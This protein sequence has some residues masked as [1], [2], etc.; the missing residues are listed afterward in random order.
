MRQEAIRI[1][2]SLALATIRP[3]RTAA[4]S[5]PPSVHRIFVC[6]M[7][8]SM[9]DPAPRLRKH[10]K[11]GIA[12]T[13]APGDT[14]SVL[15]FSGR[16]QCGVVFEGVRV[17]D[18]TALSSVQVAIDRFLQPLGLTSFVEPLQEVSRVMDRLSAADPSAAFSLV[19]MSDGYDN[20]GT[21]DAIL[22]ATTALSA[23]VAAGAV[24]EYGW[25]ANRP[26]LTAMAETL[27]VPYVF[28]EDFDRFAPVLDAEFRRQVDGARKREIRLPH[29]ALHGLCFAVRGGS[30]ATFA[31]FDGAARVP[32][33]VEAVHYLTA[34]ADGASA[35]DPRAMDARVV[36]ALYAALAVLSQRMLA[37]EVLA[38]LRLL[39]DVRL[40]RQFSNC[41]GKQSYSAF[42]DAVAAAATDEALRWADGYDPALVPPDDAFTVLDLLAELLADEGN[43]LHV[44]HPAFDYRRIGRRTEDATDRLTREERDEITSLTVSAKSAKDLARVQ[45]RM[46]EIAA[47][48]PRAVRFDANEADAGVPISSLTLNESRPNVS[49]LIRK[50]GTVDVSGN[51]VGLPDRVPTHIFRNF[52]IVRD[53]ILN[54]KR[55]PVSLTHATHGVLAAQG[56]VSG[57]WAPGEV[58]VIDLQALPIVNRRMVSKVSA[59]DCFR[60]EYDLARAKAAQKVFKHFEDRHFPKERAA[61]L[62]ATYGEAAAEWLKSVGVTDGGFSPNVVQAEATDVYV[63]RELKITLKGMASLPKVDDVS[64]KL[65]NG[66]K[67]T[68]GEALLAPFVAECRAFVASDVYAGAADP[69]GLLRTWIADK[70][71]F[72][73]R[74]TRELNRLL[75]EIKFSI[76]VGQVWFPEFA[77]LDEGTLTFV[78]DDGIEV[79]ATATIKEIEVEI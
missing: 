44:S 45:E 18:A 53:G 58:S 79:T 47:S 17:H 16:G 14:A 70:A 1:S 37:D 24:V 38:V 21:R 56:I 30:V 54:V 20:Q 65:D 78:A 46:A 3:G 4:P 49:V 34:E 75:S 66:K 35:A 72:W 19:F 50:E 59:R 71:A 77:S 15:W 26:L 60:L 32:E 5:L 29:A 69:R 68:A 76:V 31:V 9:W 7:S 51:A 67:L 23:R 28:A 40:I 33:D 74:R 22:H 39:G 6:D 27:G 41:F 36:S 61:N 57:P 52:A 25:Y 13:V 11:N 73:K 43:L 55:L 8:G 42:Q 12:M 62:K 63:G 10:L 64:A 48:K 2:D